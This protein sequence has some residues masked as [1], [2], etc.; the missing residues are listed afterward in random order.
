[1]GI[2][3]RLV[4]GVPTALISQSGLIAQMVAD[5]AAYRSGNIK[6]ASTVFD[7][8]SQAISLFSQDKSYADSLNAADL[9]HA[10]GQFIVWASRFGRGGRVPERSATTDLIHSASIA[11]QDAGIRFFLLGSNDEINERCRSELLRCY[12]NLQIVGHRNGYFTA[13]EEEDVIQS[14]NAS[15]ADVVWVGLGKPKEQVFA[16][17]VRPHLDCAW[18]ITCGGCFHFVAGDYARAP[19]W[20]QKSGLEWLHRLATGPRYLPW[21]YFVTIP[22]SIALVV[23]H[24]V[25]RRTVM[26]DRKE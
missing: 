23:Y 12:P 9:V 13:D 6:A 4:G 25:M 19:V 21:R 14:I 26:R 8:N 11:A 2:E 22:H 16:G 7:T 5:V 17:R 15:G 1:M 20:M 10:D 24:D 3:H 18:I